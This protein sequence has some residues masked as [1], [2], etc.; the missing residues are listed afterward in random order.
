[1]SPS[2]QPLHATAV[3]RHTPA[4][5]RGVLIQGPSGA[6]KS[7]LALRLIAEGWRLVADDWTHIW[8]S[9]GALYGAAPPTIAGRIEVRGLGIVR[10]PQQSMAR[11]VL[12]VQ[13]THDAVERL[14]EAA[15]WTWE[16]VAIPRL[17]L[18]PRPASAGQV[19]A[20]AFAAL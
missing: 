18:D 8:V 17:R 2:L 11:I 5:W 7:D 1:M 15:T 4:G 9:N 14:P 20:T 3:A 6:G 13:C 10:V 19:V 12:A 16:G